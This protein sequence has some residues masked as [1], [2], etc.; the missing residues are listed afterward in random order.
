MNS[1]SQHPILLVVLALLILTSTLL[2]ATGDTLS[3]G[4]SAGLP[5]MS[6]YTIP[7]NLRNVTTLKGLLFKIKDVPD[8]LV[9]TNVAATGRASGFRSEWTVV[10]G[11]VKILMFPTNTS[12]P[13]LTAGNGTIANLTVSVNAAAVRGTKATVTPDSVKAA[14]NTQQ[15]AT[16]YVKSGY[17]WYGIKGDIKAD[18]LV[19]L[20]DVLR[21]IDI[22]LGRTPSATEYEKWS[23]DLNN[24][25]VIDVADITSLIDLAVAATPRI[26]AADA[27]ADYSGHAEL[28]ISAL[29]KDV[30]GLVSVPVQIKATAPVSGLQ[31]SFKLD[32]R[33]FLV[34]QPRV[35]ELSRNMSVAIQPQGDEVGVM[36]YSLTGDPLPLN[37]GT[38]LQ[39]PVTIAEPL[40]QNEDLEIIAALAGTV[41]GG[42]LQ[43]D[44]GSSHSVSAAPE[45][46]A[47]MQNTPNPFN[48]STRITYEVPELRQGTAPIKLMVFNAQGQEVRTLVNERRSAGRYTVNWD[49]RDDAGT[50]VSSG[51]YFYK[52]TAGSVVITKKLAV[53][54]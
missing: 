2:A 9:V 21:L 3:V 38:V 4:N 6:G 5:G 29:P 48:M 15:A 20:F 44:F 23:S 54:K 24:D 30:T 10:G 25:G 33:R 8:S 35:T 26:E 42:K 18:G 40:S 16:V 51:V 41:G 45:S 22:V 49:G 11:T 17:F 50:Y 37:E 47:L 31:F 27:P 46:Y 28:A 7:V 13:L 1:S 19:N 32:S 39:I 52:L 14:N 12:T 34:A 53:T 43:T 36:L